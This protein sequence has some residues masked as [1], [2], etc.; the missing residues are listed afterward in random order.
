MTPASQDEGA[1]I[2]GITFSVLAKFGVGDTVAAAAFVRTE[3]I[4]TAQR[5]SKHADVTGGLVAE[6]DNKR[7]RHCAAQD[8]SR[9]DLDTFVVGQ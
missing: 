7:F 9:P 3:R 1:N 2:D 4:D 6:P 8:G 5:V